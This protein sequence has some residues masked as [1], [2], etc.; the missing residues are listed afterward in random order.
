MG[1]VDG[2]VMA[3]RFCIAGAG[4]Q[5]APTTGLFGAGKESF[6]SHPLAGQ[7]KAILIQRVLVDEYRPNSDG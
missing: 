6:F 5:R 2:P 4:E 1:V 3:V 7:D